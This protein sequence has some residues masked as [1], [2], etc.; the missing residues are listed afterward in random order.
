[1]FLFLNLLTSH[2]YG[3]KSTL[4][5]VLLGHLCDVPFQ[6]WWFASEDGNVLA[7]AFHRG[8]FTRGTHFVN[9]V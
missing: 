3:L 1:M 5:S 6:M 4:L 2:V 9:K 8:P 7:L